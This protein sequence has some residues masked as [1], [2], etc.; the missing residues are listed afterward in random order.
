MEMLSLSP[1]NIIKTGQRRPMNKTYPVYLGPKHSIK[2]VVNADGTINPRAAMRI[3][4]EIAGY[5]DGYKMEHRLE[6]PR[7]HRNDPT[8]YQHTKNVAK[9][10][11]GID[12][13]IGFTK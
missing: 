11:W 5:F 1:N 10:A 2:E 7:L 8:T 9:S 13:P 4:H 6:D 3:Q 12:T